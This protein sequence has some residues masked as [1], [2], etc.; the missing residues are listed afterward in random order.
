[1]PD[2]KPVN[3]PND[4]EGVLGDLLATPPPEK[5]ADDENAENDD[6]PNDLK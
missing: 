3:L 2:E 1:M 6:D 4:F 5:D